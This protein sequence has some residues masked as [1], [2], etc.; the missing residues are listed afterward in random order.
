MA[1]IVDPQQKALEVLSKTLADLSPKPL[2]G[3]TPKSGFFNSSAKYTPAAEKLALD[4][5]WIE[6]TGESVVRS[7]KR[8]ELYHITLPGIQAAIEQ[9]E[10]AQLLRAMQNSIPAWKCVWHK[11]FMIWRRRTSNSYNISN[12]ETSKWCNASSPFL[13]S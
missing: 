7:G 11:S 8:K 4:L 12:P 9:S 5:G 2:R 13:I 6:P 3:T 10:P 1:K